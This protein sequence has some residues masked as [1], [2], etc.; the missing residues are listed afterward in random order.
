MGSRSVVAPSARAGA[1]LGVGLMAGLD[2]IVFHQLLAWHHLY[3]RGS[4][5]AGLV[6]DGVLHLVELVLYLV[7][8]WLAVRLVRERTVRWDGL[9]AGVVTGAGGFQLFDGLVN[10][11]VLRLH[12]IRY[13]VD[14][15]PYD[16]TWNVAAVTMVLLGLWLLR[17]ATRRTP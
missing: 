12:Q 17:R 13:G 10:H 1:L 11:K 8:A 6:A 16:V 2:E 14:P 5:S 9:A 15:T 7:G 4:T 3:D